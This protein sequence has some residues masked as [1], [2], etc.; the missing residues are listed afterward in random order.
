MAEMT[1]EEK[2]ALVASGGETKNPLDTKQPSSEEIEASEEQGE[3]QKPEKPADETKPEPP[4]LTKQFSNLKGETWEEYGHELET[5]YQS[6]FTEALRIRREL[7]DARKVIAQLPAIQ[8]AGQPA[9]PSGQVPN[10]AAGTEAILTPE[11]QYAKTLM[12]RDMRTSFD[13]FAEQYP[14]VRDETN[15]TRFRDAATPVGQ[16]FLAIE[17]REPTYDELFPRIAAV[18]GW[19]PSEAEGKRDQALKESLAAGHSAGGQ[20]RAPS[21]GPKVTDAQV[22]AYIRMFPSKNRADAVKELE[23]A[24]I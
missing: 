10:P 14:Q 24:L 23:E 12:Q 16:A 18:F 2:A 13:H 20:G 15:F 19:Q 1:D 7:D 6:S 21:R 4:T 11:I 9:Q 3:G 22:S 5:A 17:G 8:N